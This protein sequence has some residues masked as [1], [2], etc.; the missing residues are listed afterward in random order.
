MKAPQYFVSGIISSPGCTSYT[1]LKCE[2]AY[3]IYNFKQK[4]I[5][6]F[7]NLLKFISVCEHYEHLKNASVY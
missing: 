6:V 4:F 7:S 2:I 3:V 1:N 5:K